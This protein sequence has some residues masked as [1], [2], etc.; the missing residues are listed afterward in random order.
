MVKQHIR[1]LC[2]ATSRAVCVHARERHDGQNSCDGKTSRSTA[3]EWL[4][5]ATRKG[6]QKT[7]QPLR[8][9]A[10]GCEN[11]GSGQLCTIVHTT[12]YLEAARDLALVV[13]TAS[14]EVK[15]AVPL[16]K[17]CR[18]TC[19]TIGQ[20]RG[21]RGEAEGSCS[22]N[23]PVKYHGNGDEVEQRTHRAA[24]RR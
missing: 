4:Q 2:Y 11:V 8:N 1:P 7:N 9:E 12:A 22:S 20:S 10:R 15:A 24:C 19:E 13:V 23:H 3:V 5:R 14:S 17:A 18:H 16:L 6:T 21:G